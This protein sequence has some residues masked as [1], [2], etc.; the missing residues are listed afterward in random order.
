MEE[1]WIECDRCGYPLRKL[2]PVEAQRIAR[3]PYNFIFYCYS[4]QKE[5]EGE[6]DCE[7]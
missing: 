5:I 6:Y 3:D 2:D 7:V 4:C 1:E